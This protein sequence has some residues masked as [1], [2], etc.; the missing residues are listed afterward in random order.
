VSMTKAASNDSRSFIELRPAC[1]K[2]RAD[3]GC[4]EQ[5]PGRWNLPDPRPTHRRSHA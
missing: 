2:V 5:M 4:S 1:L 3:A